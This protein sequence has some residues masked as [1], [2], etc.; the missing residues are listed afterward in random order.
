MLCGLVETPRL[1]KIESTRLVVCVCIVLYLE[2]FTFILHLNGLEL[3][4]FPR[5]YTN[6]YIPLQSPA[7]ILRWHP[8]KLAKRF[9]ADWPLPCVSLAMQGTIGRYYLHSHL[10]RYA[11]HTIICLNKRFG[12][13]QRVQF[14]LN[15][16]FND[17]DVYLLRS[18]RLS[19][20]EVITQ[21]T[22]IGMTGGLAVLGDD[23]TTLS[24][25][26]SRIGLK[27]MPPSSLHSKTLNLLDETSPSV[28]MCQSEDSKRGVLALVNW[29]DKENSTFDVE[30][31]LAQQRQ[32]GDY[33]GPVC[34]YEFWS[35][36]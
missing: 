32:P 2:F 7:H 4:L 35:Q 29:N 10:W 16:R 18:S 9:A 21:T 25:S 1:G 11:N 13:Q 15:F 24:E 19:Y 23:L 20:N 3:L 28:C 34:V 14:N 27:T 5:I 36:R 30:D 26:R 12:F 17:P 8:E 22:L 33:R 6:T 31:I